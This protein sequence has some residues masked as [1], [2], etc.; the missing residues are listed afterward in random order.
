MGGG[1]FTLVLSH[2]CSQNGIPL[3]VNS[4]E[5]G[6]KDPPLS[7]KRSNRTSDSIGLTLNKP[8]GG[9]IKTQ[10]I[11]R[12]PLVRLTKFELNPPY[13]FFFFHV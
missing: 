9:G 2:L 5:A 1:D 3:K 4:E 13:E 8:W 6:K 7:L 12:L 11:W 10:P